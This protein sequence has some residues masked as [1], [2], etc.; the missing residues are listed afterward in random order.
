MFKIH[1]YLNTSITSAY[2][3]SKPNQFFIIVKIHSKIPVMGIR[4]EDSFNLLSSVYTNLFLL[5]AT[6]IST[7]YC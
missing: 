5:V 3:L 7:I 2:A 4:P 6:H 1:S